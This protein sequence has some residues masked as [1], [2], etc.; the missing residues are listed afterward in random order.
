M[1]EPVIHNVN[2]K[3]TLHRISKEHSKETTR[4]SLWVSS[5]AYVRLISLVLKSFKPPP[6]S[7]SFKVNSENDGVNQ[8]WR[9]T[10]KA[11]DCL[12]Q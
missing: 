6:F 5:A 12:A 7:S 10:K 3:R 4:L 2:L 1:E 8:A 11:L 9:S